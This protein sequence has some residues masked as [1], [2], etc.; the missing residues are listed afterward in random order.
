MIRKYTAIIIS[1]FTLSQVNAQQQIPVNETFNTAL[2]YIDTDG[3]SISLNK[4]CVS[5]KDI[6]ELAN[7]Y[8][9]PAVKQMRPELSGLDFVKLLDE[10]G[11]NEFSNSAASSKKQG[12]THLSKIFIQTNGSR[13][14]LLS[15]LGQQPEPWAAPTY[16]PA[17]A[18][19]VLETK[20]DLSK[21]T[22][23]I[24]TISTM[25][26]QEAQDSLN[27]ALTQPDPIAGK[28][29]EQLLANAN[30]RISLY[31]KLDHEKS[32]SQQGMRF[33]ALTAAGRIDG[34][35]KFLWENYG[36]ELSKNIPIV[37]EGN[38]HTI[39]SPEQVPAPWGVQT[40]TIVID[41]D[42]NQIWFAID[43][44]ILTEIKGSSAK[45]GA[46]AAFVTATEGHPAEGSKLLY[47]SQNFNKFLSGLSKQMLKQA[48]NDGATQGMPS[49]LRKC[50]E[51][52]IA[53]LDGV[54]ATAISLTHNQDGL[55]FTSRAA[56]PINPSNLYSFAQ[57]IAA[58]A[59]GY[60]VF[61]NTSAYNELTD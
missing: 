12:D 23:H 51:D 36:A 21:L 25:F 50:L 53:Y 40:P 11:L 55:L 7:E 9:L 33:P 16:A 38:V 57:M 45:L 6:A 30:A 54:P 44:S 49:S 32:W 24:K 58:T 2:K 27:E 14:G 56:F 41:T 5:I 18:D 48:D 61:T 8:A 60:G 47:A 29:F 26:P 52:V 34:I 15:L 43:S 20:L 22:Q 17:G 28:T 46:D 39:T 59:S 10:I 35:A 3:E 13:K 31:A 37:T 42:A 4:P 1:A 19:L